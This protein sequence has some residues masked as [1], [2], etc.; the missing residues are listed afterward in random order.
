MAIATIAQ[1]IQRGR[2]SI[3]YAG[4]NN[5]KGDLFGKRLSA[6]GSLVAIA[7]VTDA[8]TWANDGATTDQEDI[9]EMANYLIWLFGVYGQQA[10]A[11][12]GDTSGG[13]SL[14]PGGGTT[15]LNPL[16][17]EVGTTASAIAPLAD[18]ESSV[19]LDG[20]N[21]MPDL[22]GY[23]IE[24]TRGSMTQYT[25]NVGGSYYSWDRGTGLFICYPA[26][27]MGEQFRIL[28]SR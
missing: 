15:L 8:L 17:W 19:T 14:T 28:P 27:A 10:Q 22:R 3:G 7:M 24:F 23:N 16:D 25:T 12:L 20:T 5:A 2:L 9:R 13:G 21:G 6:P 18:G 4:N 26:A 1:T 11:A